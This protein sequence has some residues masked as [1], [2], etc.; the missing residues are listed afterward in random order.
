MPM[1]HSKSQSG[2]R[3]RAHGRPALLSSLV[4]GKIGSRL[5]LERAYPGRPIPLALHPDRRDRCPW[6]QLESAGAF[7]R[8]GVN[9]AAAGIDGRDG[10]AHRA[11]T[12]DGPDAEGPSRDISGGSGVRR[13]WG[14][15]RINNLKFLRA[16]SAR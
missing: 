3:S 1:L 12:C 2:K 16:R 14:R 9:D 11:T 15:A 10:I 6:G 7:G 13:K 5:Q 8:Q 4:T